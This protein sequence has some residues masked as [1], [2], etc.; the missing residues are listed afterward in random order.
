MSESVCLECCR[1]SPKKR[2]D[3]VR[4]VTVNFYKMDTFPRGEVFRM[5]QAKLVGRCGPGVFSYS[6]LSLSQLIRS[7]NSFLWFSSSITT[8]LAA[9]QLSSP[10]Q[11]LYRSSTARLRFSKRTAQYR[12]AMSVR[13]SRP[14]LALRTLPE[15][16][17]P[18]LP[19]NHSLVLFLC[20]A[21]ALSDLA[22]E[23]RSPG[24][25]LPRDFP[26]ASDVS[27]KICRGTFILRLF[28]LSP[29]SSGSMLIMPE[30][31]QL[32]FYRYRTLPGN[33]TV[34]FFELI[35][36]SLILSQKHL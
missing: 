3:K 11:V 16:L 30:Q 19:S 35:V 34:S 26:A 29:S 8:S 5:S 14:A 13:L 31:S 20:R 25:T 22:S 17:V 36:C 9:I 27:T 23:P 24:E 6:V 12:Q 32:R 7:L 33:R 4:P 28:N 15:D 2:G 10:S 18:N 1:A 21:S